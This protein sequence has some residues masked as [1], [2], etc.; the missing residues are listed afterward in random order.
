MARID[1]GRRWIGDGE[2][3]YFVAEISANH[4]GDLERAKMLIHLAAE[5]GADAA[6]FQ[7]FRAPMI[8]SQQ[9]FAALGSQL[10]HQAKWRK[11]VYQ[12]YQDATLP[13]E[14]TETLKAEC[15]K[16]KI[17]FFSAPYDFEAVDMLTPYVP[18]F[19]IGSGDITWP[20][21]LRKIAG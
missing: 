21:M 6:K 5:L 8:V 10:S 16:A 17:D 13:W 3:T 18:I 20:E 12:V 15:D 2:P 4:D 9:G 14:W 11:T 19:K 7:N 1:I